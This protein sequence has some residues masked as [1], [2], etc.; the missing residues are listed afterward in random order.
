MIFY[1]NLLYWLRLLISMSNF[2]QKNFVSLN[3]NGNDKLDVIVAIF[4]L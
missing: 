4:Y 3:V 1:I 2:V